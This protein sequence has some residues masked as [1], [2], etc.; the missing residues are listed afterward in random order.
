V[1]VVG[2]RAGRALVSIGVLPEQEAAA[3]DALSGLSILPNDLFE[4]E[5]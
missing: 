4:A 5:A 1:L 3:R 2:A